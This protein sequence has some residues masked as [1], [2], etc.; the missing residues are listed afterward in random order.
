MPRSSQRPINT[1]VANGGG[2][3]DPEE[4]QQRARG[5]R[6]EHVS[7]WYFRLNGFLSIPGFIV[8]IDTPEAQIAR[9]G[10]PKIARTEADLMGVRFPRSGELIDGRSMKDD[11]WIDEYSSDST[12][13]L[14]ILVET[15]AKECRM[16]GPW[17]NRSARNMQRVIRRLGFAESESQID[18]IAD[19]MYVN[20]SWVGTSARLQYICVGGEKSQEL[21]NQY[22]RLKQLDWMEIGHFLLNRFGHFPAKLPSDLIHPQWPKFGQEYA[23][24]FV[25]ERWREVNSGASCEAVVRYINTGSCQTPRD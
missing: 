7:E 1:P 20:A 17:T 15:K 10:R 3:T 6:A 5:Q 13:P 21:A 12:K 8:H 14:F 18:E 23:R 25:K 9:N 4:A 22:A 2:N 16:N 24:W 19:S 11:S